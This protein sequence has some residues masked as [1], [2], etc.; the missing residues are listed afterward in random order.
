MMN[1]GLGAI[2]LVAGILLAWGVF[3]HKRSGGRSM[4]P[5]WMLFGILLAGT[6]YL[7]G[8][9]HIRLR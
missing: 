4:T 1:S 9:G 5:L 7:L 8:V 6:L 2:L 3:L